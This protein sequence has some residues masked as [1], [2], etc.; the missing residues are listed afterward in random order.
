MPRNPNNHRRGRPRTCGACSVEGCGE[1]AVARGLCRR[2]YW[3]EWKADR[4]PTLPKRARMPQET[5]MEKGAPP[6]KPVPRKAVA[7]VQDAIQDLLDGY[8]KWKRPEEPPYREPAT[9]ECLDQ[10]D[11]K[12]IEEA[13][14]GGWVEM[15]A[16]AKK[17]MENAKENRRFPYTTWRRVAGRETGRREQGD[18]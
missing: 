15:E 18:D 16:K 7:E 11:R 17:E 13:A 6:T 5:P 3:R 10:I 12:E 2:H 9:E 4:L 1:T 8:L 14:K